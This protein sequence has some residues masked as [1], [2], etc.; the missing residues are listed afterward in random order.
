VINWTAWDRLERQ[1]LQQ[2]FTDI[3]MRIL[4]AGGA[5]GATDL[6]PGLDVLVDWD[7]FNEAAL[8]WLRL[9]FGDLLPGLWEQTGAFNWALQLNDHT[10]RV[11]IR[12]IDNWVREGAELRVLE[13]RLA[14]L[15]SPERARRIA[16][17]EVTRIYASG[18]VMAW[19]SSGVVGAKMWDSARD[20]LVCP[21]CGMLHGT[22]VE[23]DQ[24]WRIT[25]AMLDSNPALAKFLRNRPTNIVIPPGHV[26]CRC[27]LKPV[28]I[29]AYTESQLARLRFGR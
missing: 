26:E 24:P 20:E 29:G 13:E 3:T 4:L 7:V 22:I 18:N 25:Q 28:V 19:Q 21:L 5:N 17:T 12:E 9:Y 10:R 16:V 11:L 1:L 23:I 6:P 15:F 8:E 14:P 27:W 2:E